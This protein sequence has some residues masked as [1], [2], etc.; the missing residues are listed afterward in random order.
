M[1]VVSEL[2]FPGLAS[3]YLQTNY[4]HRI[5]P[6]SISL[7][8]LSKFCKRNAKAR[9]VAADDS[10]PHRPVP[11]NKGSDRLQLWQP[12]S[13]GQLS[14]LSL[15]AAMCR[16]GGNVVRELTGVKIPD[17]DSWKGG[18]SHLWEEKVAT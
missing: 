5:T 12:R 13:T 14:R 3:I 1:C 2:T 7:P 6:S 8:P 9:G 15:P 17:S 10:N 16:G 11:Q 18:G 4:C